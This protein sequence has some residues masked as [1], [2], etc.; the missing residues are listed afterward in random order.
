M[1]FSNRAVWLRT[2]PNTLLLLLLTPSIVAM[3]AVVPLRCSE[4]EISDTKVDRLSPSGWEMVAR[5]ELDSDQL[6]VLT[7][8]WRTNMKN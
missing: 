2:V 8:T 3:V 4:A 6:P 5:K 1:F 7:G